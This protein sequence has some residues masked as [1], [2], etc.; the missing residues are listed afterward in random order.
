MNLESK[1][2]LLHVAFLSTYPPRECGIATF[3]QD[4]V[5]ELKKKE[6]LKTSVIAISDGKYTY[7][8]DVL[9]DFPQQNC[10]S[11]LKAAE[12]INA[13]DIDFLVVE[14]EYGIYGG[15]WGEYLLELA[16]RVKKPIVTTLHTILPDPSEKQR[17]VLRELCR[18]SK[19]VVTMASNSCRILEE[20]YGVD[21]SK[22]V[23]IPHGVPSFNLPPREALKKELHLENRTVISTFGLISPGKGLEYGIEA[24][25]RVAEKHPDVL[26]FILGQTHPV[27]RK[28]Y[29][30]AYRDSLEKKVRELRL[31]N[32][33]RF[34]N[35]YLT[36]EEIVRGLQLSDIYMTPYLNRDQ[37]VSG[38]LAYAAGYGRVIV[39]TPYLYAEEMLADGRGLL[40][41]FKDARSLGDAINFLI[42][43]PEKRKEMEA[44]T[45]C[46]GK[47]M[48]WDAVADRYVT[49][50]R[51]A[52]QEACERSEA[53]HER[54][55]IAE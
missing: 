1:E 11:Y 26:Y 22:I 37:A 4:L 14:H 6:N 29:G 51:K 15:D 45:L 44:K 32:N 33:V 52:H 43:H 21:P 38:T 13:S 30:E 3:T 41:E 47:T 36:K 42:E 46:F 18:R 8:S 50:F 9:F 20:A 27:V 16:K 12:R 39:S 54:L 49:T 40:A 17:E 2:K 53:E 5:R 24:I 23:M 48:R 31:E 25:A 10:T 7:G 55:K 19:K 35:K 28:Q 34:V